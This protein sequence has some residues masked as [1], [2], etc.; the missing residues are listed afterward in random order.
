[1]GWL[2]FKEIS[3]Y[4]IE[5]IPTC[6]Y[7][8]LNCMPKTEEGWGFLCTFPGAKQQPARSS[9]QQRSAGL[10][11]SSNIFLPWLPY[12]PSLKRKNGHFSKIKFKTFVKK[13]FGSFPLIVRKDKT[14]SWFL[15]FNFRSYFYL[16]PSLK[17]IT[18]SLLFTKNKNLTN[19]KKFVTDSRE[20]STFLCAGSTLP[21]NFWTAT[22]IFLPFTPLCS[23]QG[24]ELIVCILPKY[25]PEALYVFASCFCISFRTTINQQS[26]DRGAQTKILPLK[27]T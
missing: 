2:K 16:K 12:M 11:W 27:N 26:V 6:P 14:T 25:T 19:H 22:L 4:Q 15:P 3:F 23:P 8:R 20:R 18:N 24:E 7:R 9:S 5:K 1:M 21:H 17:S 10:N 13:H